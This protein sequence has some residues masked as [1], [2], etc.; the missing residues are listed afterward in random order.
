M[1]RTGLCNRCE[2]L[3]RANQVACHSISCEHCPALPMSSF[4]VLSLVFTGCDKFQEIQIIHQCLHLKILVGNDFVWE[5]ETCN[6]CTIRSLSLSPFLPI[7]RWQKPRSTQSQVKHENKQEY[8][9]ICMCLCPSCSICM[10]RNYYVFLAQICISMW[11]LW[12]FVSRCVITYGYKCVSSTC[13]PMF[14]SL[15]KTC[16]VFF[17]CQSS[18]Q[19]TNIFFSEM[20]IISSFHQ[21]LFLRWRFQYQTDPLRTSRNMTQSHRLPQSTN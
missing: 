10:L 8:P 7:F 6:S 12:N 3:F 15:T 4:E 16:G 14:P 21:Y 18:R 5:S 19:S 20:L 9:T 17:S 13:L 2:W 11:P 1:N